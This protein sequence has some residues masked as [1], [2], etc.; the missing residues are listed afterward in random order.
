MNDKTERVLVVESDDSLRKH[1]AAALSDAGYEVS[2]D[3]QGGMR[4]VLAFGPD[5]VILGANP[6]QLD[7]CDLLSEIKGS[8]NTHNIRV[9]M[10][11]PGGAAERT[12]GLDLGADD[13]LSLP[14]EQHEL[15][16]RIR[17][18][19]QNKYLADEFRERL[20]VAEE[21]RSATAEVVTAVNE[22][23]RTLRVGRL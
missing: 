22:G 20:R 13:V 10:L 2:T 11:S 6:P 1:I 9:V 23:R 7:C 8:E 15:L 16:S 18:Q 14:F 5:A 17:S 4:A 19:L 3:Y 12:R 21:N